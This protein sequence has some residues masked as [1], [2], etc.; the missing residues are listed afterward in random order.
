M[1]K[2][3]DVCKNCKQGLLEYFTDD[4]NKSELKCNNPECPESHH[5]I[6]SASLTNEN[7][8]LSNLEPRDRYFQMR[9]KYLESRGKSRA[10]REKEEGLD[11]N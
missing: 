1:P 11:R 8:N 4:Q 6:R 2:E 3:G 9:N 5:V 7:D 10:Q